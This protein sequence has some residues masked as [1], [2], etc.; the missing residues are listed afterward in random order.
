[1]RRVAPGPAIGWSVAIVLS[2]FTWS[3]PAFADGTRDEW[4]ALCEQQSPPSQRATCACEVDF[5][6]NELNPREEE[7]VLAVS[8]LRGTGIT[9]PQAIAQVRQELNAS[10]EEIQA[11]GPRLQDIGRR[12]TAACRQGQ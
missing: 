3:A 11:L 9:P 4:I 5:G 2:A 1:M 10:E 7:L 12:S 6:L 8:R